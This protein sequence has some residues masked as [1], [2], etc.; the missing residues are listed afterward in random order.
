MINWEAIGAVGEVLGA[1][2]VVVTLG[3]L[4]VQIRENSKATR[5]STV[6]GVNAAIADAWRPFQDLRKSTVYI[7]G[8]EGIAGLSPDERVRFLA[9]MYVVAKTWEDISFQWRVGTLDDTYW[10]G[11]KNSFL[12]VFSQHGPHEYWELCKHW[13]G[14]A[15]QEFIEDSLSNHEAGDMRYF[16]PKPIVD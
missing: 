6:H 12:D 15:F 11:Q 16:E 7:A 5:A 3:Y 2:G 13:F 1:I 10:E 9:L 8:L 4:A 14:A